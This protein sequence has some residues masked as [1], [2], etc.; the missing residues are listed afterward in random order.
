M[1]FV[2]E[3][4]IHI[5]AGKGGDGCV[6]FHREKFVAKGGP[7]GGDGG[8]G[9]SVWIQAD[10]NLNTLIEYQFK[11]SYQA[12][13]GEPGKG[14]DMT[15]RKGDDLVLAVPVGT[16]VLD[17]DTG[18]KLI[19][20]TEHGQ[21]AKVA[22]GGFHGLGNNR[23]KSSVN[24]TP[25]QSTPGSPGEVRNLRMELKLLADVGLLGLPN[26]GKSTLIR[27]VSA[28]R[29]RVA[30]YPF[31]TLTPNLGVVR[32]DALQS[33]VMADIP[34]LIAGAASGAGLGI[35]FLKHL[36]RTRLLLHLVDMMPADQS[37]PVANARA[38]EHELTEFSPT[39]AE[40][41][42]WLVLTKLDLL[43]QAEQAQRVQDITDALNWS[44]PVFGISSHSGDGLPALTQHI[45]QWLTA[46][47]ERLSGDP[48]AAA[49]DLSERDRVEAEAR[50]RI[51]RV[52]ADRRARRK[53][54]DDGDDDDDDHDVEIEYAPY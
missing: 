51:A 42:R 54:E 29:P 8:D 7:N 41:P 28:A 48:E 32:V 23:F 18:E 20:L 46:E 19:D 21:R 27:S 3:A 12:R 10:E 24:R 44:G 36:V 37:D 15:G 6:S 4:T 30:D 47:R 52:A 25:R 38:I 2:D 1:K 17:V 16:T 45:S 49:T 39:M 11:R 22:Q 35:R 14:R 50:E 34:G 31:T 53:G 43:P 33:F 13:N 40:R 9:G 5:A 26:A